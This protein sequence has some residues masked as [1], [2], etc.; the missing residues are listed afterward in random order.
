MSRPHAHGH[1]GAP[2][3]VPARPLTRYLVVRQEDVWFIKFDGEEYG[4]YKSER[5]AMLFAIDAAHKLGEQGEETEVLLM[6]ENCEPQ[7]Q[8]VHG[9][10]AYPPSL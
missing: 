1:T 5:E 9:H 3:F 2:A 4:P 7:S 10:D 8:W 6:D